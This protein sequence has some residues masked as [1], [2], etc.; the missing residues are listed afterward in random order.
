MFPVWTRKH[1][2]LRKHNTFLFLGNKYIVSA[3]ATDFACAR[4]RGNIQ[5]KNV[6]ATMFP[7]ECFLVCEGLLGIEL[8]SS[9]TY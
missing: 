5:G 3:N 7:K 1:P 6:S 9:I 2:L 8:L 4:K